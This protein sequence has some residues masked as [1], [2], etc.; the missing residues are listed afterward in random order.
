MFG[1]L[2]ALAALSVVARNLLVVA[3]CVVGVGIA[4][5]L[6][7]L[8]RDQAVIVLA[9][10]GAAGVM[11]KSCRRAG[12]LLPVALA[13]A[14]LLAI[15]ERFSLPF[16]IIRTG[17]DDWLTY[18]SYARDI[19]ETGSLEAGEAVFY[20]QPFFRYGRF[21][22]RMLFGD[23][24]FLVY[25]ATNFALFGLILTFSAMA[26]ARVSRWARPAIVFPASCSMLALVNAWGSLRASEQGLAEPLAWMLFLGAVLVSSFS[27]GLPRSA[28]SPIGA[29]LIGLSGITRL[30][31]LPAVLLAAALFVLPGTPK[32]S[33]RT[34]VWV[35][36]VLAGVLLLPLLHNLTY[37]SAWVF[38]TRSAAIPANLVLSPG[39]LLDLPDD[40]E[41]RERFADQLRQIFDVGLGEDDR[42]LLI[43]LRLA[44]ALWLFSICAALYRRTLYLL[45]VALL[46]LAY[47]GVHLFY[48][49][50][51]YYPRHII[52]GHLAMGVSVCLAFLKRGEEALPAVESRERLA[53]ETLRG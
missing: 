29:A 48:Q 12:F 17:G 5:G 47:L 13:V 9:L 46:P 36:L 52:A 20:Y 7:G 1:A 51:V 32:R 2:S 49:T 22:T 19:L 39:R 31:H 53:L 33:P 15:Y 50:D 38:L 21:L 3:F 11:F 16:M 40:P 18:E 42:V 25:T 28:A 14:A 27:P 43:G 24:D 35:A 23:G 8:D 4:T 41:V 45:C 44:Q 6:R 34:A 26:A 30:N 37:G 10:A